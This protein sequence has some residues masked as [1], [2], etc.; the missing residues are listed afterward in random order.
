MTH[1]NSSDQNFKFNRQQH[2]GKFMNLF[3]LVHCTQHLFIAFNMSTHFL[4][5]EI[6]TNRFVVKMGKKM[7]QTYIMKLNYTIIACVL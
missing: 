1:Q 7:G 2:I 6:R 3:G 4:N 5:F